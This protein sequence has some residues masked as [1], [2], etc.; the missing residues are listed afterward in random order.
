VSVMIDTDDTK[1][2]AES[3]I[4]DIYFSKDIARNE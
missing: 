3:F 1:G 4:G 2:Y